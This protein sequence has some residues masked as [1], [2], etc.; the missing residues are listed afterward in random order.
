MDK[1]LLKEK[2]FN[3]CLKQQMKSVDNIKVAISEAQKSANEYGQPKDRYDAYRIQL[4]RKRDMF[5]NQLKIGLE[6]IETLHKINLSINHDIVNFGALVITD[7]QK[8]FV[9]ISLGKIMIDNETYYA[10]SPMVP[11]YKA[12]KGLK[13]GDTFDFRGRKLKILDIF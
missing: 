6:Q 5:A 7:E 3:E 10:I 13:K 9:S 1:S 12:M 4:L 2:L 11:F 8:L